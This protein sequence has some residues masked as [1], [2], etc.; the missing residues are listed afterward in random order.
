MTAERG[1]IMPEG[2]ESLSANRPQGRRITNHES[3]ITIQSA[4][5]WF[6]EPWPW[7]LMAGPAAVVAAGAVTIWLA[8]VSADGLVADDYYRRGLA[9]N[10]ELQRDLTASERGM[11]AEVEAR[12]GVLRVRITGRDADPEALFARLVHATRA[13]YDERV[14]LAR[15]APGLYQGGMPE[16]PRG[17]WRIILED[18]RG[19][20]RLVK[21]A[22]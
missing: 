9:I 12:G 21:E 1:E 14:R 3:R 2:E 10:Q 18:P 13:G 11:A 7:I 6:K 16:L 17:R 20:W 15:V 5:P 22:L 4:K 8:F 19:Q